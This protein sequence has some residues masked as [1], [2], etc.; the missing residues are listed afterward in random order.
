M[1]WSYMYRYQI[2]VATNLTHLTHVNIASMAKTYIIVFNVMH[3]NYICLEWNWNI[4]TYSYKY[5]IVCSIII[6][7]IH[8]KYFPISDWL[9]PHA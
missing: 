3:Y 8:S 5:I 1:E 4:S 2:D 9:K 7:I 6:I